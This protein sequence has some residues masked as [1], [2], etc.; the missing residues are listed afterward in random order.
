MAHEP[1]PCPCCG[2][3]FDGFLKA[4]GKPLETLGQPDVTLDRRAFLA[5]ATAAT[6]LA[7][8]GPARVAAQGA[9]ATVF[10]G[11]T[12]LTV[13]AAFSEA[14]ALAIRGNRIIA[15]GSLDE[16]RAVAGAD[17][18]EIDLAGRT[19]LPGFIDPHTH[20][21]S[22]SAVDGIMENVGMARFATAAEVLDHLRAKVA[23]TPP[24]EW[25][26]G[27]NYDPS[28]QEGF[29]ALTFAELDA[30]ST[31]V[32]I[33]LM[34][35]SGHLAYAN[36][37]AFEAAGIPEDV[38][39]PP[40]AEYV[41]DADGHLTG[42][43]KN[44]VAFVPVVSAAP[45]MARLDPVSALIGLLDTWSAL[46]L[47]T[48][49]ELALG[50]LSSSVQD[51]QIMFAAA[52]SGRLKARIR[53]YPFYTI[54]AAEWDAAGLGPGSGDAL[55]R[56]AGYKLVADGSNQGFTGFQREPYLN[57]DSRG[58]PYMTQEEMTA[59]ALDRASKGWQL[60]LHGNGDAGIDMVLDAC[61]A[62]RDAGIDMGQVRARIE[63]CS[64]LHDDQ[65]ARMKDLGVSASFLIG[66]VHFWGVWMRD[67][68]FGPERVMHLGRLHSVEKAGIGYTLHSDFM[69]TEPDPLH[70]I[71]MAVTRRTWR[72]P[73]FVLNPDERVS[74]ESAIRAL[75]SEAAWQLHSEHE[76][77]SL[78]PGKFADLVIL[79][80]DPR[81]VAPD[82]IGAIRVTE[83]WMDGQRVYA[84]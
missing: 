10:A 70:M 62:V 51:A 39:D 5:A 57:S 76:I 71:Q 54:G 15:V 4:S 28:L 34:N 74:V 31:E 20:V 47:T 55:A 52:R 77:G 49:S 65:I 80:T 45:A 56:I 40:G 67:R 37:K 29:D 66:H 33:F 59:T 82:D 11:G 78:E 75:T 63:H 61:T 50:T 23:V 1:F 73:D 26:L 48:V 19:M 64:M 13:D 44:N 24:G 43:I 58:A 22:G 9:P 81:G 3:A 17:A 30:I 41:R 53:A 68:V 84:A 8:A 7:A 27:R 38:V 72:E 83:T 18:V 16:V 79:E 60:A 14:E 36:R 6:G 69:V 25:V 2:G 46:G 35:A 12:I 42:V 21:V 32:P